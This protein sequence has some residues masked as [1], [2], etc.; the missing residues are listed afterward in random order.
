M[1]DLINVE[2]IYASTQQQ[3]RIPVQ[4]DSGFTLQQAIQASGILL[5]YPEISLSKNTVGIFGKRAELETELQD[6]DQVEIYRSLVADPKD[7]RRLRVKRK[8][9]K[10]GRLF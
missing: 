3:T 2:V 1:N 5:L 8:K 10:A 9:T 4:L 7:G 6:R